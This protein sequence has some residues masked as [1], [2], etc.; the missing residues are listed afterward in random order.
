[1]GTGPAS[2][3]SKIRSTVSTC[4]VLRP[5]PAPRGGLG[6]TGGKNKGS[7]S[8]SVYGIQLWAPT[9]RGPGRQGVE[10]RSREMGLADPEQQE[11]AMVTAVQREASPGGAGLRGV[12]SPCSCLKGAA[13]IQQ[14]LL[15]TWQELAPRVAQ[16]SKICV[17][18]PERQGACLCACVTVCWE[19]GGR[20]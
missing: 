6:G 9:G 16:S 17:E 5:V 3:G 8:A 13:A 12:E 14:Q 2:F 4:F 1:M 11:D 20:S 10:R 18:K 15:G 7:Q 19:C